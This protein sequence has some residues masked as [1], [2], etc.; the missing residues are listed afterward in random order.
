MLYSILDVTKLDRIV[1]EPPVSDF[2]SRSSL[3]DMNSLTFYRK[4]DVDIATQLKFNVFQHFMLFY[5]LFLTTS[6]LPLLRGNTPLAFPFLP[7]S[8]CFFKNVFLNRKFT[9]TFYRCRSSELVESFCSSS[10]NCAL[11]FCMVL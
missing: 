8:V 7:P 1:A 10:Q 6:V 2:F 4:T 3:H 9:A 5:E 11:M